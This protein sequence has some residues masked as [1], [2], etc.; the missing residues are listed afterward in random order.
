MFNA[1]IAVPETAEGSARGAAM[2]A[3]IS[4]GMRSGLEDFQG[5]FVPRQRI[6]PDETASRVYQ[7]QHR[8]FLH[9]LAQIRGSIG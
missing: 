8:R 3:M 7:E 2:L 9:I 5:L 1:V 4:L 6:L